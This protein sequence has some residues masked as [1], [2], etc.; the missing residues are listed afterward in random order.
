MVLAPVL[1]LHARRCFFFG[2]AWYFSISSLV[3]RQE[4]EKRWVPQ[5]IA[6]ATFWGK[7]HV[8]RSRKKWRED[9]WGSREK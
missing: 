8:Q 2:T 5:E 1:A 7:R 9:G 6:A 4:E 3:G